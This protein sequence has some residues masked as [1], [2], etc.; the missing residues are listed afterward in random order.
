MRLNLTKYYSEI[1]NLLKIDNNI[2][3]KISQTANLFKKCNAKGGRVVFF[4][5]GGSASTANH[6]SVDLSKNAKISSI[7]FNESNLITCFSNDCGY[8]NWMKK[9]IELY[10]NKND[11]IVLLSVSG[12]SE[13]IINETKI[14]KKKKLP[15]ITFTGFKKNKVMKLNE[16][17]INFHV[18]SNSYNIVEIVH[19]VYLLSI[20]DFI[21]GKSRYSVK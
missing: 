1:N 11:I 12:S 2:K 19:H 21:I 8:S 5:N 13:N 20:V 16:N 7:N 10:C 4:G 15:I 9:S 17:G 14:S 18:K 3:K 6:V